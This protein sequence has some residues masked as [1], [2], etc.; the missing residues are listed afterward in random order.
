MSIKNL[1]AAQRAKLESTEPAVIPVLLGGESVE[2]A[3]TRLMPADWAN[4]IATHP[5]RPDSTDAAVGYHQDAV[6]R[7]YPAERIAV[8]EESI[9]AAE[10]AE[11]YDLLEPVHKATIG[12]VIWG[13]NVYAGIKER[14]ELGKA[15]AGKQR[16]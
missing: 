1:I 10:W 15:T 12:T 16:S 2:V 4:L 8:G 13:L 14:R 11:A 9:D 7:D 5:P 3:I 6:A